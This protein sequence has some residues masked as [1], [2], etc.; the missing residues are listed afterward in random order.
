ML[1]ERG[2]ARDCIAQLTNVSGPG[3]PTQRSEHVASERA[4]SARVTEILAREAIEQQH[5]VL[6]AIAE[7]GEF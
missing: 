6:A 7:R 3:I 2:E 5:H 1:A 4:P